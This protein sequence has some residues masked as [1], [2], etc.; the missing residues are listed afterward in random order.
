MFY[1]VPR[2]IEVLLRYGIMQGS[3]AE[4]V[5]AMWHRLAASR[6]SAA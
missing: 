6:Q 5:E 4:L 1:Q 2:D 3:Q